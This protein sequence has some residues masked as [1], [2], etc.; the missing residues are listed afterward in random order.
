M[1]I[2]HGFM[3]KEIA[4]EYFAIPYDA[5]YESQD[6]ML[7]LNR[8]GA[9]LWQLLEEETNEDALVDTLAEEYRIPRDTAQEAVAAFLTLL[10]E[11]QLLFEGSC[12]TS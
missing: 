7:S 10:R 1:Q 3:V 11:N 5:A 8:T 6:Q 2:K 9:F 12:Q 4:G